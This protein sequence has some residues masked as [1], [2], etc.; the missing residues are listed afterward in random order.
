M[1]K[2]CEHKQ[3]I[4]IESALLAGQS[5]Q[6]VAA[7]YKVKAEDLAAHR[8]NCSPYLLSLG[9]LCGIEGEVLKEEGQKKVGS[10]Q[11]SLKT[12]EDYALVSTQQQLITTFKKTTRQINRALDDLGD[13]DRVKMARMTLTKAVLDHHIGLASEIRQISKARA[14]IDK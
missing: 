13:A 7:F 3:R 14:E 10:L 12:S 11:G 6:K 1:C 4:D 8:E 5:E 2:I 9:D